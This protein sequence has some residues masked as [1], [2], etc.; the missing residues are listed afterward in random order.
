M[1]LHGLSETPRLFLVVVRI[2]GTRGGDVPAPSDQK[3]K[4]S[5][6]AEIALKKFSMF[7]GIAD[8][9]FRKVAAETIVSAG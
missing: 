5:Y 9:L 7:P 2:V 6:P 1:R 4:R 3:S 8:I